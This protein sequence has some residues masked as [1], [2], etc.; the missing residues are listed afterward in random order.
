MGKLD[1]L[2]YFLKIGRKFQKITEKKQTEIKS[3]VL[4]LLFN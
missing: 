1:F 3:G 4:E 2:R